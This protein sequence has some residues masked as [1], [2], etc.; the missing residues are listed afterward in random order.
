M[1]SDTERGNWIGGNNG[2]V[3]DAV[4][5]NVNVKVK[6][7]NKWCIATAAGLYSVTLVCP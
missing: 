4:N 7:K 5:V 1:F 3:F 6:V 2:N